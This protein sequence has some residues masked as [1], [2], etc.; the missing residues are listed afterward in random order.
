MSLEEKEEKQLLDAMKAMKNVDWKKVIKVLA[1]IQQTEGKDDGELNKLL[2]KWEEVYDD[3]F[4]EPLKC[5]F[6]NK[7][8][9]EVKK[10]I[11]G[12]GV[13]ICDECVELCCEILD[14][15]SQEK[16]HNHGALKKICNHK[17]CCDD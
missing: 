15:E 9:H 7:T 3:V 13:Y 4:K 1:K 10:L 16:E 2:D 17:R 6:C 12:P 11:A 5:S 14:E 8:Q